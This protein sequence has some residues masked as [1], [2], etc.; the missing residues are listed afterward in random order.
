ME[1]RHLFASASRAH[2]I[3]RAR[4]LIAAPKPR[5]D[6]TDH[7]ATDARE[8]QTLSHLC[9]CCG[10]RMIIIEAFERGCSPRYRPTTPMVAIRIDT[11]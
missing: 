6:D 1:R 2:N 4:E 5:N 11:S 7:S 3:A 9:R 10:G 8:P